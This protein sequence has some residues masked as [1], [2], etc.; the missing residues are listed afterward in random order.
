MK[1]P[2]LALLIACLCMSMVPSSGQW[3]RTSG[4]TGSRVYSLF[5]HGSGL[6]AG[7]E[8]G[9]CRST[10]EGATWMTLNGEGR[11]QLAFHATSLQTASY[12]MVWVSPDTGAVWTSVYSFAK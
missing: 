7:T 2:F 8:Y 11:Y 10:N 4:P 5:A 1:S 12:G 6:F 9:L 3:H